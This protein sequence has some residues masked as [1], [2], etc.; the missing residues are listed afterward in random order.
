MGLTAYEKEGGSISRYKDKRGGRAK[1]ARQ[2]KRFEID[3]KT[4]GWLGKSQP[5]VTPC[6]VLG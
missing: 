4:R 2:E 6:E 5:A 3:M 1:T